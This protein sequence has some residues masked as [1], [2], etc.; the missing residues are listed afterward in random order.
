MISLKRRGAHFSRKVRLSDAAMSY[1]SPLTATRTDGARQCIVHPDGIAGQLDRER[2]APV[3]HEESQASERL[4]QARVEP[5]HAV[6]QLDPRVAALQDIDRP[7]HRPE[8]DALWS[9]PPS[10]SNRKAS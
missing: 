3:P 8:V 10:R 1:V 6:A 2:L 4:G 9:R 5:E 7:G